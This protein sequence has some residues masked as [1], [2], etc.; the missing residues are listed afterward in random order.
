MQRRLKSHPDILAQ[1]LRNISKIEINEINQFI[2]DIQFSY[3]LTVQQI[4]EMTENE[5][6][7][8]PP[9]VR[10][11]LLSNYERVTKIKV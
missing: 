9:D 1:K 10:E 11:S 5:T 8:F 3:D 7:R 2:R 6:Y 4:L